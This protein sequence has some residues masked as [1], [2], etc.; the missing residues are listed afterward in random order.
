MANTRTQE[1]RVNELL[2]GV[3]K[4]T[5]LMKLK[6]LKDIKMIAATFYYIDI[7]KD[8]IILLTKGREVVHFMAV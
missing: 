1:E 5:P 8:N 3:I 7:V 4:L 2:Y 6:Q